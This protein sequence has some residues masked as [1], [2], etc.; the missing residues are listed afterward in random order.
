MVPGVSC[1]YKDNLIHLTIA[2]PGVDGEVG[3]FGLEQLFK[4]TL[5]N[6]KAIIMSTM[7]TGSLIN[8]DRSVDIELQVQTPS[9]LITEIVGN[10][11]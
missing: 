4:G 7:T 6:L 5:K 3:C 11:S 2:I 8:L 9:R 10:A 1:H